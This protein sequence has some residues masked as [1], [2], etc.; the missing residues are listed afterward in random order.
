ME[1]KAALVVH[2]IRS[3]FTALTIRNLSPTLVMPISL[4]VIWSSSSMMSPRISFVLN[5]AA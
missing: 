1:D 3:C 4:N 5:V 2:L